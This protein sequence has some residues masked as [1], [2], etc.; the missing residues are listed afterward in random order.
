MKRFDRGSEWRRWDLHIHS[1][2]SLLANE[3]EGSTI[4]E[5]WT[6]YFS[7]LKSITEISVLGITD[8]F[9]LDGYKKVR[10]EF[11]K[12]LLPN[13]DEIL[14]NCEIRVNPRSRAGKKLNLHF[15][16]NPDIVCNL[17]E[18]FFNKL[19]YIYSDQA[20]YVCTR[21]SMINLGRKITNNQS[22]EELA[23]LRK[24]AEI[25]EFNIDDVIDILKNKELRENC[26]I[27]V[28]NSATDGASGLFIKDNG[29]RINVD[30]VLRTRI[31]KLSDLIFSSSEKDKEYFSSQ[32]CVE[33]IGKTMTCIHGS[34]AHK[35]ATIGEPELQRYN[36]IKADPTFL[37]L[38]QL[39]YEFER[40]YIGLSKP[41][42]KKSY[43]VIRRVRFVTKDNKIFSN[44]WIYLNSNLVTIIGGK[45][46][47]KSLLTYL[48]SQTVNHN[49]ES[50]D[51]LKTIGTDYVSFID[52]L[53]KRYNFDFI[54]EWENDTI[55]KYSERDSSNKMNLT[56]IAQ[57]EINR[58]AEDRMSKKYMEI[59]EGAFN[60]YS[61][62]EYNNYVETRKDIDSILLQIR[63]THISEIFSVRSELE[64]CSV[65][66]KELGSK[67]ILK[68]EIDNNQKKLSDILE[69]SELSKEEVEEFN[70]LSELIQSEKINLD[71]LTFENQEIQKKLLFLR[72]NVELTKT[73]LIELGR[74]YS[75]YHKLTIEEVKKYDF[76]NLFD[77]NSVIEVSKNEL[78]I[79]TE[80]KNHLI[81]DYESKIKPFQEKMSKRESL[82]PLRKAIDSDKIAFRQIEELEQKRDRLS[83][84]Q[85]K[86][87]DVI[88][89]SLD[90]IL[91][92][93]KSISKK[94]AI[95]D[96]IS[97]EIANIIDVKSFE[98]S[99]KTLMKISYYR[100]IFKK[101]LNKDDLISNQYDIKSLISGVKAILRDMLSNKADIKKL[102][103]EYDIAQ[104]LFRN[105][106]LQDINIEY[107][108][109]KVSQM[110]PGKKGMV[111]LK[112]I[113]EMNDK[114]YPIII[115]QPEDNLDNK[116]IYLELVS[117]IK[118]RKNHRQ[119]IMVSHNANLTV[120]TDSEEIVVASQMIKHNQKN[121]KYL[122]GSLENSYE[123]KTKSDKDIEKFG[124]KQHV[125]SVLEGGL[126]AFRRREE[127]YYI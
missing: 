121:F 74:D 53:V 58:I 35:N 88:E 9:Y 19:K 92:K 95:T 45:S 73:Y 32:K 81:E 71:K 93:I 85:K 13:I 113:I 97:Y 70:R 77:V 27:I 14:P 79:L 118:N 11:E 111:L 22:L 2:A 3:F 116:T 52:S 46:T 34:D 110:S 17:D 101:I 62:K 28:P 26:L 119:I 127:K 83:D 42:F 20:E 103:S 72:E 112:L 106:I 102:Y 115:D 49:S 122:S 66:L 51:W 75:K 48:I 96:E 61:N 31:Y 64:Q 24:A 91:N 5:K 12:G 59:V 40:S 114:A 47:G 120:L 54:V 41:D 108:N 33:D 4:E 30:E 23:A 43:N 55:Q 76:K 16:F 69:K 25:I 87:V 98:K 10:E 39:K 105:V 60:A 80:D 100:E 124:I 29:E 44:D 15:I 125:C 86:L 18:W 67:L 8:Y 65:D 7:S 78:K 109:E 63:N 94:H 38:K 123:D 68:Q 36:W 1:P 84:S 50:N 57:L 90:N 6:N 89:N 107:N 104:N 21:N 126:E 82:E 117:F 56:Y 37:G 99:V